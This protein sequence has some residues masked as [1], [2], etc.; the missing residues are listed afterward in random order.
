MKLKVT[1][2]ETIKKELGEQSLKVETET[3]S[4]PDPLDL[5]ISKAE[6]KGLNI[7]MED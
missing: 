5:F 2:M 4:A 6:E 3:T 7:K 1:D